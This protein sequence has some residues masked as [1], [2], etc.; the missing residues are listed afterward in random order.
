MS[1]QL[2]IRSR[3]ICKCGVVRT[4]SITF[5]LKIIDKYIIYVLYMTGYMRKKSSLTDVLLIRNLGPT[6]VAQNFATP[7]YLTDWALNIHLEILT[8][9]ASG[10]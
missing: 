1:F 9:K 7:K 4:R 8:E 5:K 3:N 10:H 2:E 6:K